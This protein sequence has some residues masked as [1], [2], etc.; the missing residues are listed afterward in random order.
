MSKPK[1]NY[2]GNG[3]VHPR[4][5][6]CSPN[7]AIDLLVPFIPKDVRTIWEPACGS[8]RMVFRLHDD[9]GF[10]VTFSDIRPG[11]NMET[12]DF[13]GSYVPPSGFDA[14]ITNPPYSLKYRFAERCM[15]RDCPWALLIPFDASQQFLSLVQRGC[16]LVV[17]TRRIDYIT[18]SGKSGKASSAQ[19]HSCWLTWQFD[20]PE[21]LTVVELTLE[22]KRNV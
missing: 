9:H 11:F 19:F 3:E 20:V 22:Q 1:E 14:A 7:Y 15:E 12:H 18:P 8:G 16:R 5:M 17:P 4:D 10:R 2:A 13:L 21:V 6:F